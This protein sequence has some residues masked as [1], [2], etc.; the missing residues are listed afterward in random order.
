LTGRRTSNGKRENL[1]PDPRG[2]GVEKTCTQ[3]ASLNLRAV[4]IFRKK[5]KLVGGEKTSHR[6]TEPPGRRLL[7]R[8][9]ASKNRGEKR[10]PLI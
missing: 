2:G 8:G 9:G 5:K 4:P 1:K 7:L 6:R 10:P 3:G